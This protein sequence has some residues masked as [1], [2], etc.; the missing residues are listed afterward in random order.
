MNVSYENNL[1]DMVALTRHQ[2]STDAAYNR[3]RR[4][5]L[6]GSPLFLLNLFGIFAYLAPSR[7]KI[8]FLAG[9]VIGAL[10]SLLWALHTYR[11]FARKAVQ[12]LN[13]EK[14]QKGVFCHHTITISADG[15]SEQTAESRGFHTWRALFDIAFTPDHI[16]LY[17]TPVTAYIIPRREL[18]DAQFREVSDELRRLRSA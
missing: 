1:E 8:A 11:D 15:L 7:H 3:C 10:A 9:G 6:Y 13:R 16:F 17:N 2:L 18:G 5:N 12:K 14:P 4:W